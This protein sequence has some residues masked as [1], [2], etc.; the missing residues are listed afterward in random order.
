MDEVECEACQKEIF[1]MVANVQDK[2][3]FYEVMSTSIRT[4]HSKIEEYLSHTDE[5][6]HHSLL[7]II[8]ATVENM[9]QFYI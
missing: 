1:Q 5:E 4:I 6:M 7:T 9:M 3:A 2:Y 8:V